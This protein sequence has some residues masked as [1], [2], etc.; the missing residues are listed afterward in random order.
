MITLAIE[1]RKTLGKT[2][3]RLPIDKMAAIYYG[4]K[5][6]ATPILLSKSDFKKVFKKAGESTVVTLEGAGKKIETLI[7]EVDFDPIKGEPRHADFYVLEK[8]QKV[9]VAVPVHFEGESAAVKSGGILVKVMHQIEV[10]AEAAHLPH[11]I[12]IDL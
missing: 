7:H 5:E 3:K 9:R 11:S 8:G 1:E 12:S 6:K 10:E 2:A 4:R